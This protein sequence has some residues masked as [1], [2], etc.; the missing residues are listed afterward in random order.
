MSRKGQKDEEELEQVRSFTKFDNLPDS[1]AQTSEIIYE[2]RRR[3][4][5][6]GS[7]RTTL[8]VCLSVLL[9]IS[10]IVSISLLQYDEYFAF[11]NDR[12]DYISNSQAFCRKVNLANIDI[13]STPIAA[14]LLI[15]YVV[16]YKRRIL[17]RYKF[18]YRNIGIPMMISLW[19]KSDRVYSAITYGTIAFNIYNIV[20]NYI[21]SNSEQNIIP[22]KDPSGVLKLLVKIMQVFLIGIRYYPVLVAY[23]A[24]SFMICMLTALYMWIDFIE[25][26]YQYGK[27]ESISSETSSGKEETRRR[28]WYFIAYK[29]LSS[30]PLSIFSSFIVINLTYKGMILLFDQLFRKSYFKSRKND[31]AKDT[32][33]CSIFNV[34]DDHELLYCK[35]DVEY[36][37]DLFNADKSEEPPDQPAKAIKPPP[38]QANGGKPGTPNGKTKPQKSN[39]LVDKV[40]AVLKKSDRTEPMLQ[41]SEVR[42]ISK[43]NLVTKMASKV[44]KW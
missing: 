16:L 21:D 34:D 28:L 40:M 44:Y 42:K 17:W 7:T 26:I 39:P 13:I 32:F 27:C 37:Y 11:I 6:E 23:R 9:S 30:I 24:N 33:C 38:P 35:H 41:Y 2:R 14:A 22:F 3:I 20:R 43:P 8:I 18:K 1:R 10:A 29:V 31:T 15:L 12:N 5:L 4:K 36:V 19:R 25:N